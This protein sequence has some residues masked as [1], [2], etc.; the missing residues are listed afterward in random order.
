[1]NMTD[2]ELTDDENT[3]FGV[4]EAKE[5]SID[6]YYRSNKNCLNGCNAP[7]AAPSKVICRKCIDGIGEFLIKEVARLEGRNKNSI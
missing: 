7:I 3:E 6:P 2:S 5:V 4:I 1:M